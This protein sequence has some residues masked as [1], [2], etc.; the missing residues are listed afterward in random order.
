MGRATFCPETPGEGPSCLIPGSG[1]SN[2][3]WLIAASLQSLPLSSQG[4]LSSL[5]V[6]SSVSKPPSL[7][8]IKIPVTGFRSTLIQYDF[9]YICKDL[10]YK[11]GHIHRYQGLG[12]EHI[13]LGTQ[14]N[15]QPVPRATQVSQHP[16]L[17]PSTPPPHEPCMAVTCLCKA[18]HDGQS[19]CSLRE[20]GI[21]QIVPLWII[22]SKNRKCL[23]GNLHNGQKL[24]NTLGVTFHAFPYDLQ[25]PSTSVVFLSFQ[26]HTSDP[27]IILYCVFL[28]MNSKLFPASGPLQCC[29]SAR[30][31]LRLL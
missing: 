5:C 28:G 26:G 20:A 15:S 8:L 27:P 14:F 11:Y 31:P 30:A 16:N 24:P 13:F 21:N 3:P 4:R 17:C 19:S 2:H 7:S 1:G 22:I 25:G 29:S 6:C 10:I 23:K 12:F 18:A 9:I